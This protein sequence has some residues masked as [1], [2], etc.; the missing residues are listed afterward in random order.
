MAHKTRRRYSTSLLCGARHLVDKKFLWARRGSCPQQL[1]APSL[2]LSLT[3]THFLSSTLSTNH[4]RGFER[5]GP[6]SNDTA[7]RH[8]GQSLARERV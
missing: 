1:P 2:S 6:R 8:P 3:H 7:E 4:L 5:H